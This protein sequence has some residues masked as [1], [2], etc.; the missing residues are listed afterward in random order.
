W[1]H[2]GSS[3]FQPVEISKILLAFFFASYFASNRELLSTPTQRIGRIMIVPPKTLLPI[4]FAWGFAMAVLGAEND[5][6]FA[7][8]L[9]ALFISMLWITTG[10]KTYV[11]LGV[12]LFAGGAIIAAQL[13]TQVHTRVS[14]W[15]NP[16]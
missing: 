8:L 2:L 6:G 9:F 10:L 5:I 16:W 7:L 14:L 11:F 1:V 13:F 3:S 15:L 12:G 4:L